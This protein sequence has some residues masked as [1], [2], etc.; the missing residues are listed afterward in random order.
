LEGNES[1]EC[2][3]AGGSKREEAGGSRVIVH[4]NKYKTISMD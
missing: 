4:L 1:K 3:E 2:E